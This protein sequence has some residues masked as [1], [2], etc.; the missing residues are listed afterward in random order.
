[1][2]PT[3][4][5]H[6]HTLTHSH[7]LTNRLLRNSALPRKKRRMC[8]AQAGLSL[9]ISSGWSFG[10]KANGTLAK[11]TPH[12]TLRPFPHLTLLLFP[13]MPAHP[14]FLVAQPPS[15]RAL[16]LPPLPVHPQL[17]DLLEPLV[18]PPL[19]DLLKPLG[20]LVRLLG[21]GVSEPRWWPTT[22]SLSKPHKMTLKIQTTTGI[23][24][25]FKHISNSLRPA[26]VYVHRL[27]CTWAHTELQTIT[28]SQ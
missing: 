23:K 10:R 16:A 15:Q 2:I 12:L 14:R 24:L 13:P 26:R 21:E 27:L 9:A 3:L 25:F 19:P 20:P 1:M 22:A 8:W 28:Q 18:L 4:H 17:P 7:T 6:T 5:A 11:Y